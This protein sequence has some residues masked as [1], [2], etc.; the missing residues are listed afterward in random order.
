[1]NGVITYVAKDAADALEFRR[2]NGAQ[3]TAF[4]AG[5]GNSGFIGTV[6]DLVGTIKSYRE[7]GVDTFVVNFAPQMTL[8]Q[9]RRFGKEVIPEAEKL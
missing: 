4:S 1:L 6:G 7:A 5:Q 8:E 3:I 9:L 2:N